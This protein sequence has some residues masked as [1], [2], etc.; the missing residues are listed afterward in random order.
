VP[1]SRRALLGVGLFGASVAGTL[2]AYALRGDDPERR[3]GPGRGRR[4]DGL[5]AAPM[6]KLLSDSVIESALRRHGVRIDDVDRI[7][8]G[9]GDDVDVEDAHY[10]L[11]TVPALVP[12]NALTRVP[13]FTSPLVLHVRPAVAS[14]LTSRGLAQ[15]D[16]V[17]ILLDTAAFLNAGLPFAMADPTRSDAAWLFAGLATAVLGGPG[18]AEA[19]LRPRVSGDDD[20][21]DFLEADAAAAPARVGL[22]SDLLGW[23][24][25]DPG[26]WAQLQA[27]RPDAAAV[28]L[29]LRPTL[30]ATY[31]FIGL[32]PAAAPLADALLLPELQSLAQLRHGLRGP[33]RQS[34]VGESYQSAA[35]LP[36]APTEVVQLP[37]PAI[38]QPLVARLAD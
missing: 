22:E 11:P 24:A 34:G 28:T 6:A 25:D 36:P 23:I 1:V 8:L 3:P 18:P 38:L 2:G 9:G 33:Q 29:H 7:A 26:G 4:L 15:S 19:A 27:A 31:T 17:R 10:L 5:A 32:R 21:D 20:I 12:A 30:Y 14:E 35:R 13:L 37:D 16:G